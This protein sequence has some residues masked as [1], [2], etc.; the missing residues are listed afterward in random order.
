MNVSA[1]REEL[2]DGRSPLL[3]H[4]RR[5]ATLAAVGAV[6]FAIISLY[7]LGVIRHLPDPPGRIFDSDKVNASTSAYRF[8]LPDGPLGLASYA[9]ILVLA[10]AGGAENTGRRPIFDALLAAAVGAGV[11]GAASYLY[12]M[13]RKQQRACAYCLTGA[14][15]NFAMVPAAVHLVRSLLGKRRS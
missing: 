3:R 2:R 15:V 7:Q 6:D 11:V 8:G 14:A 10:G 9:A 5:L 4:R 1:I 13:V 12:E